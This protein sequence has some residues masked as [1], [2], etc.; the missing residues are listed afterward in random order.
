V[1]DFDFDATWGDDYLHFYLPM[2]DDDRNEAETNE[3]VAALGLSAGDRVLDA[4]CGHGRIANLLARRGIDVVGVDRTQQFLD[5][6]RRDA[7]ALGVKVDYRLGDMTELHAVLNDTFDAAI[8]WFTSFGYHDDSTNQAILAGYHRALRPDGQL[9][10]ET[11]HRDWMVRNHVPAPLVSVTSVGDDLMLD[12]K[13][14]DARTGRANTVRTVVRNGQTRQSR[15]SVRLPSATEI[16]A[17][18][19]SADFKD[20]SITARDGSPLTIESRRLL[21]I[22]RA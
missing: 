17:W 11:L 18:L 9:L 1:S 4:P 15:F 19:T 22:A 16:E 13:S 20:I 6:A 7:A 14:F 21:A 12:Q 8:N 2:L 3:I 5:L 10:L